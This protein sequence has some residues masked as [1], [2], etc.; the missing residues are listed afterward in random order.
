MGSDGHACE[1]VVDNQ[2]L[3]HVAD[4]RRRS[5]PTTASRRSR[6][7]GM[8]TRSGQGR[9]GS[10]TARGTTALCPSWS[11]CL[12]SAAGPT[13]PPPKRRGGAWWWLPKRAA[14]RM[15]PPP[16]GIRNPRRGPD[17]RRPGR[18]VRALHRP[19]VRES[20]RHRHRTHRYERARSH[21]RSRPL[22][23]SPHRGRRCGTVHVAA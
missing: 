4:D 18:R 12:A 19:L 6:W 20:A 8:Q 7:R 22:G 1:A 9:V 13:T 15:T 2:R 16:I 11:S 10:C 14:R 21:C 3:G 17:R 5:A 23:S